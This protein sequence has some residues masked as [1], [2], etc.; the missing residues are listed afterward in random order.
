MPFPAS[1]SRIGAPWVVLVAL[2]A[3]CCPTS[4]T[5]RRELGDG[6]P[7]TYIAGVP[8][9]RQ[10]RNFCG[11]A[12][13]ASVAR[14]YGLG[15]S[16]EE[17]AREVYLPSIRAS[18]TIDLERCAKRHGLWCRS[19]RGDLAALRQWLDRG[20]PV[21]ALLRKGPLAGG[22][23]H[24]VV[25]VGYH[26]R[27][28]YFIA[29]TG[30]FSNRP[31]SFDSFARDF[32]RA[33][34][35]YLA[36][37][38]PEKVAWPLSASEF[39]DLGLLFERK[40]DLAKALANYRKAI[41]AQPQKAVF[42]F[43]LAN[44]LSK[45][46]RNGE[47]EANYREAIRLRPAF[48]EAH[49]NLAILLLRVGRLHEAYR[50]ARRAVAIDGPR[51]ATFNET[52]GRVLLALKSYPAAARAFRRALEEAGKDAALAAHARLGLIEALVR[53]GERQQALAERDRLLARTPDPDI[54]E[55]AQKLL[56]P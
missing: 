38:P 49:N 54:R 25:L 10:H 28:R 1:P 7:G 29:H 21:V 55:R 20:V 37:C 17:I 15:L 32:E 48:A 26:A 30:Y 6:A 35:W 33:G 46:G 23:H 52:L 3:G 43:N 41:A 45:L 36:A 11:P 56:L 50:E 19:G 44:V 9:V 18:L 14:F 51:A 40:G 22:T 16:Q 5:L 4:K 13:L 53:A 8:F 31:L 47:A 39:N 34:R 24:Y 12:A 2:A 42:H 27:R